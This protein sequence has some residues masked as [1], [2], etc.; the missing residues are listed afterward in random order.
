M[1]SQTKKNILNFRNRL[2]DYKYSNRSLYK[3]I[4]EKEQLN[5]TQEELNNLFAEKL[6]TNLINKIKEQNANLDNTKVIKTKKNFDYRHQAKL[7]SF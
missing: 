4:H 1:R 7:L 2:Q 3:Q 6:F 5:I